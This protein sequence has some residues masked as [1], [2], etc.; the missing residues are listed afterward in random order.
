MSRVYCYA[1]RRYADCRYVRC[2]GAPLF[3]PQF[4]MIRPYFHCLQ[5]INKAA[6]IIQKEHAVFVYNYLKCPKM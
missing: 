2:R 5:K 6:T 1:E 3:I 4:P